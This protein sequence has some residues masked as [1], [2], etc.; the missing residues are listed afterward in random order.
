MS[1]SS[2]YR[3]KI[4]ASFSAS[5]CI[6]EM[7]LQ[8]GEGPDPAGGQR[9]RQGGRAAGGRDREASRLRGV[10]PAFKHRFEALRPQVWRLP[11]RLCQ[12][13]DQLLLL[14]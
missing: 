7:W 1:A 4:L 6:I 13:T 10:H 2:L 5:A 14:F 11:V 8:G 3:R 9:Q 12:L